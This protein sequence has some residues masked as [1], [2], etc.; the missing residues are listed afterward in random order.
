MILELSVDIDNM[1]KIYKVTYEIKD[2][3][4]ELK[5]RIEAGKAVLSFVIENQMMFYRKSIKTTNMRGN[6]E[7][8]GSDIKGKVEI[9]PVIVSTKNEDEYRSDYFNNWFK[10]EKSRIEKSDYMAF[11][12]VV[13]FDANH[14]IDPFQDISSIFSIK[15]SSNKNDEFN[16][17]SAGKSIEIILGNKIYTKYENIKMESNNQILLVNMLIFPALIEV[18]SNVRVRLENDISL[19]GIDELEWYRSLAKKYEV[20]GKNFKEIL[21]D[22]TVSEVANELL[23]GIVSK[24]M[25][26]V[27]HVI[28][29]MS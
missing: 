1:K 6:F 2:I 3:V 8:L 25:D 24:S 23:G 11:S 18:L 19:E 15:K 20:Q 27:E 14:D 17:A 29:G 12:K 10:G 22:H 16:V 7:L 5:E 9:L 26:R 21:R 13:T 28:G 4:P